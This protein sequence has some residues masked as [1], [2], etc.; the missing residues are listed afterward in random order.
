M[1]RVEWA[2][3]EGGEAETVISNLLYNKY[4]RAVRVR[5]AQGDYGID[6][7][8]PS[9]AAPEPWDI[10]QIKKFATNLEPGHKTQIEKSFSR[11]L[12]GIVRRGFKISNWYLVMPLDP[13]PDNLNWFADLPE[14]AIKLAKKAKTNP[15]TVTEEGPLAPGW[16]LPDTRSSGR[17]WCFASRSQPSFLTWLITT[18]TGAPNAFGQPSTA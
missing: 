9:T 8:I 17:A 12:L 10:Y 6:V 16:R 4:G 11:L 2:A 5:P 1:A 18:S 3:L 7:L 13:T 14:K 15:M